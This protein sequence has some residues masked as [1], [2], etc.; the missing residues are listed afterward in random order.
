M[1]I[2]WAGLPCA[3]ALSLCGCGG[4][5]TGGRT[6]E[7]NPAPVLQLAASAD[8]SGRAPSGVVHERRVE[9]RN[10]GNASALGVTVS[11]RPDAQALQLPLACETANCTPRS[12]GGVEIAEV[13]AG[14]TVTLRQ[15]LRIKPGYR[16]AVSNEWQAQAGSSS[17]SWRQALTAVA[18]DLAVAVGEPIRAGSTATYT[19]TLTNQ[20]PD[21]AADISW[22]LLTAPGQ[23]WRITDCTA[24]AGATCP[25]TTG[26]TMKLRR[27]PANGSLQLRVQMDEAA[28]ADARIRGLGSRAD[29]AGDANATND[30]AVTG[31][32]GLSRFFMADL[33]GRHYQLSLGPAGL[34][35]ATAAGFDQSRPFFVDVSGAGFVGEPGSTSPPWSRGTLGLQGPVMVLGL[36]IAGV[37]KPYLAARRTAAGLSELEGFNFNVLGSRADATGKPVDAYAGSA[38]FKDGALQLCLAPVPTPVQQCAAA[39]LERFEAA[40][41]GSE[42]ELV[43]AR[44]AMRAR[45]ALGYNG[46]VL[47]SSSRD[48]SGASE[49]WLALP[50]AAATRFSNLGGLYETTFESASGA[51][52][53]NFATIESGADGR[54]RI[55]PSIKGLSSAVFHAM[56]TGTLGLCGLSAQLAATT[57]PGRFDGELRGDWLTGADLNGE[58]VKERPCFAGQVHHAQTADMAVLLGA[59]GSSLMGRWMFAGI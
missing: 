2:A 41:V 52:A 37:R 21:E 5:G 48:S 33:E 43:S 24:S 42:I 59:R 40:M 57:Q 58:F 56:Q 3:A 25:P 31:Q 17:A 16:G 26:E 34:V 51:S 38:R 36:D 7:P 23:V 50:E 6:P 32:S 49:F 10:V 28:T 19:V 29:A 53:P 45:A 11:V 44:R 14:G 54:L 27:L 9:L 46:P 22:H 35:R 30:A 13:P 8:D 47:I 20:G 55:A 39:D 18:A 4:G 15:R 1:K 12:D